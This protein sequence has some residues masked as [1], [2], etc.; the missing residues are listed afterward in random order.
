MGLGLGL[1][2]GLGGLVFGV[3]W[4]L[5]LISAPYGSPPGPGLLPEPKG[6]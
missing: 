1:W 3:P 4:S 6:L 2:S 5:G